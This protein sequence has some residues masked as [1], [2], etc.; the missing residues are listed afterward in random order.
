METVDFNEYS[1]WEENFLSCFL[2]AKRRIVRKDVLR[3]RLLRRKYRRFRPSFL[4]ARLSDF[5]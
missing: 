2:K 4:A 5:A 3:L 1:F